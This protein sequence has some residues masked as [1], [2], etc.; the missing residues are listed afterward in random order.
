MVKD[1]VIA[2]VK[3]SVRVCAIF[4]VIDSI[5]VMVRVTVS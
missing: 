5:T 4:R 3:V 2:R 1:R